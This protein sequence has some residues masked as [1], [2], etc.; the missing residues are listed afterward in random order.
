M[1]SML[2]HYIDRTYFRII[3]EILKTL[4]TI[5]KYRLACERQHASGCRQRRIVYYHVLR[6]FS[7][8]LNGEFTLQT[9]RKFGTLPM[10]AFDPILP[11]LLSDRTRKFGPKPTFAPT[12]RN[13]C[14]WWQTRHY[15]NGDF[16]PISGIAIWLIVSVPR[17]RD[18]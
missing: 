8:R 16:V 13:S 3:C 7:T 15:R 2:I 17:Y 14:C 10:R 1:C 11:S 5:C 12:C 4:C 18:N 6:R 9:R